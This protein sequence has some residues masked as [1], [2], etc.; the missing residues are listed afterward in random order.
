MQCTPTAAITA[1]AASRGMG[2]FVDISTAVLVIAGVLF[3]LFLVLTAVG[4]VRVCADMKPDG[5]DGYQKYLPETY[6][7][8]AWR[9][10]Y[11]TQVAAASTHA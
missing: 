5:G 3:V 10:S 1:A 6:V 2:G 8:P 11:A 4:C 9:H 7:N